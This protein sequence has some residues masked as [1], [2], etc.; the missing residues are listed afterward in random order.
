MLVRNFLKM[1]GEIEIKMERFVQ[2]NTKA[3][4][5]EELRLRSATSCGEHQSQH[6]LFKSDKHKMC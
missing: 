4:A 5:E 3:S 2:K 1:T 6:I